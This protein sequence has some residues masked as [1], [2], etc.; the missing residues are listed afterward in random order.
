MKYKFGD[1]FLELGAIKELLKEF[2][3][4]MYPVATEETPMYDGMVYIKDLGIYKYDANKEKLIKITNY[5]YNR[6]VLN[7]TTTMS[8]TSSQ[9][10][11]EIHEYLGRYLRF[12]RDYKNINLMSL[13]NCFSNRVI[14]PQNTTDYSYENYNYYAI[15]VKFNRT[16]TIGFDS[17]V[18]VDMYCTLW[19]SREIESNLPDTTKITVNNCK[20][21]KPFIYSVLKDINAAPYLKQRENLKLIIKLPTNNKTSITVL[22]GDYIFDTVIDRKV[23]TKAYF[24]DETAKDINGVSYVHSKTYPTDLSLFKIN[25]NQKHPFADRLVEYLLDTAVTSLDKLDDNVKRVQEYLKYLKGYAPDILYGVWDEK[26][27]DN[28][29][30]IAKNS[31]INRVSSDPIRYIKSKTNFIAKDITVNDEGKVIDFVPWDSENPGPTYFLNLIDTCPDLLMYM[32]K[33]VE[34]LFLATGLDDKY[35]R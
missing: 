2:N 19:D 31:F 6:P 32:D 23:T 25:D 15:P 13:Y 8:V 11:T 10:G 30:D 18:P 7:L 22:E 29:Y 24:G 1:S 26:M 27:N 9:Y 33:D 17:S 21:N 4:P 34:G 16:Y 12:L 28:I 20:L 35:T 3:L 14:V 5:Y